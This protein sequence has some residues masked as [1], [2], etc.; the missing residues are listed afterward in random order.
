MHVRRFFE[1]VYHDNDIRR[2]DR[3]RLSRDLVLYAR[4]QVARGP[5]TILSG[6]L[7]N[8]TL[9]ILF[10]VG[11][12][13]SGTTLCFQLIARGLEVAYPTNAS[14]R[15]FAAPVVGSLLCG[16]RPWLR[17]RKIPLRSFYGGT[18]GPD[19]PH[20]FGWFWHYHLPLGP[21]NDPEDHVLASANWTSIR[22]RLAAMAGLAGRPLVLKSLDWTVYNIEHFARQLPQARF[23]YVTRDPR[24]SVQSILRCRRERYGDE[25]VWWAIRP[26]DVEAWLDR[27]PIAQ[28]CHQV[29][30]IRV[31]IEA[32]LCDLPGHRYRTVKYE[33]L[34]EDPRGHLENWAAWLGTRA[35]PDRELLDTKL[36]N[37]NR[38]NEAPERITEITEQLRTSLEGALTW[39]RDS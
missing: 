12:P 39:E 34:V 18:E 31:A 1:S 6:L 21:T 23:L 16:P 3:R 20:E 30:D 38:P 24:F 33:D 17:D 8:H 27:D 32:A 4:N 11:P 7:A 35:S 22:S 19:S 25:K 28:A 5:D 9:P 29:S 36:T 15:W 14:S 37:A 26:R 10:I 2:Q 13:R